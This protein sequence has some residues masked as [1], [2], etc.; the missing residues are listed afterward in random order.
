MRTRRR[1]PTIKDV[2]AEAGTAVGT[3]SRVLN[4]A[5]GVTE[6]SRTAVL[7]AVAKL[8]YELNIAAQ[9]MRTR[10]KKAVGFM[11]TDISN[12][13]FGQ[14]SRSAETVLAEHGYSLVLANTDDRINREIELLQQFFRLRTDGVLLSLSDETNPDLLRALGRLDIPAVLLD[15]EPADLAVDRVMTDHASGMRQATRYLIGLGHRRIA[16]IGADARLS[17]GRARVSGWREAH[18]EAGLSPDPGLLRLQNLKESFGFQETFSLLSPGAERPT[19]IIAGGNRILV[20]VLR[21][22]RQMRISVPADLSLISCDDTDVAELAQPPI[23]V[24]WRDAAAIGRSSA[25]ILMNRLA[26]RQAE[27]WEPRS[28]VLP[29]ELLVRESCAPPAT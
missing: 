7:A 19:A 20:G 4:R 6:A 14:I 25:E 21:A 28:I 18:A 9:S 1:S 24:I 2:A 12:P 8:G 22:L 10:S 26:A 16:L 13:L 27:A 11:V 29:T 15:R 23:T 5:P 3:V 17:A